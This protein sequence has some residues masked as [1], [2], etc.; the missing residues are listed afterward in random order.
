M[1]VQGRGYSAHFIGCVKG[2]KVQGKRVQI[3]G[4]KL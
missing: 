1:V 3:T 4:L 2:Y